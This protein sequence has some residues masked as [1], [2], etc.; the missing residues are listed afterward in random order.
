ML[1]WPSFEPPYVAGRAGGRCSRF[2][3]IFCRLAFD[4]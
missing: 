3:G 1:T 4:E 2:S